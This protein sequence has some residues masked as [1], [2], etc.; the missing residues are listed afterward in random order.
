MSNSLTWNQLKEKAKEMWYDD[1][2]SIYPGVEWLTKGRYCF[3]KDGTFLY[4]GNVIATDIEYDK[5]LMI[6][7]GL[8]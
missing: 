5:M 4:D 1:C 2:Y 8:E 3:D 7:R 6:M